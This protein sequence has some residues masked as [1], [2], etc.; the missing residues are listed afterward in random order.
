MS[1]CTKRGAFFCG[2]L[3]LVS[4]I[5]KIQ[6]AV[7]M[8]RQKQKYWY[9]ALISAALSLV[10]AALIL[11]NPFSSTAVLWTFIA[12]SLIVEAVMDILTFIF[13]KK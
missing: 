8:S 11:T 12:V 1:K 3:I 4:G 13:G 6:W 10:F 2:I 5:G 9:L 7:D